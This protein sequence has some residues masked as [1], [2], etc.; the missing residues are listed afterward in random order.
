MRMNRSKSLH[1][2]GT[3]PITPLLAQQSIAIEGHHLAGAIRN[4]N[5]QIV[6][7]SEPKIDSFSRSTSKHVP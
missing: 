3:T 1:D 7:E 4:A 5:V 2:D 6:A